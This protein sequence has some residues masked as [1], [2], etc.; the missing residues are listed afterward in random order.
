[1]LLIRYNHWF[2]IWQF[3]FQSS[4]L[5]ESHLRKAKGTPSWSSIELIVIFNRQKIMPH[6][7]LETALANRVMARRYDPPDVPAQ[8]H[9]IFVRHYDTFDYDISM[10]VSNLF[11]TG[12]SWLSDRWI[13]LHDRLPSS[14]PFRTPSQ[15]AWQFMQLRLI[16]NRYFFKVGL[17]Q[18]FSQ[19]ISPSP[20]HTGSIKG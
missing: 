16:C 13:Q 6:S 1:M 2:F 10:L 11:Y 20:F 7:F 12:I 8:M 5:L 4:V 17:F 14:K 15:V 3:S 18:I 9:W 19:F